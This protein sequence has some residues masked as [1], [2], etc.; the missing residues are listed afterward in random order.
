[1]TIKDSLT[2]AYGATAYVV[3]T[4]GG[5]LVARIG[6]PAPGIEALLARLGHAVG[7]FITGA[8]PGSERRTPR[9]NEAANGRLEAQLRAIRL[10]PLPHEGVGDQGDWSEPGFFVPGLDIADAAGLADEFGQHAFVAVRIGAPAS[11]HW[12]RSQ[13]ARSR[14]REP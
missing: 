8:N 6:E 1:M 2:E 12:T 4:E 13:E 9:E 5:P 10:D 3:L 14:C 7:V 11:L